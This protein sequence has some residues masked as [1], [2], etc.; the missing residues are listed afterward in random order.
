[1]NRPAPAGD[2]AAAIDAW[3]AEA[4]DDAAAGSFDA[5]LDAALRA[6]SLDTGAPR[7]HLGLRGSM[8]SAGWTDKARAHA[9][10]LRRLLELE[11]D[12]AIQ[13]LLDEFEVQLGPEPHR[14]SH[15]AQ[16]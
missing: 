6:L 5:A 16:G 7:V 10:S 12:A 3:L 9:S 14:L 13:P 4:R 8:R 1:M 11:P 15:P 2:S